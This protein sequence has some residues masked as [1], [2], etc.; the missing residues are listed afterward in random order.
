[1][2]FFGPENLKRFR[3]KK[4][5]GDVGGQPPA[6]RQ[7]VQVMHIRWTVWFLWFDGEL[8][9]DL[10]DLEVKTAHDGIELITW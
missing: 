5:P 2:A 8:L 3:H 6:F 7:N 1:M 9:A 4:P 10:I